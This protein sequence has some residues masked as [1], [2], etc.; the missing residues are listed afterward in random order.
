MPVNETAS[1]SLSLD[2]LRKIAEDLQEDLQRKANQGIRKK[3]WEQGIGALAS[4][5]A[6]G[7]FI[8]ICEI[9]AGMYADAERRIAERSARRKPGSNITT[10]PPS[11]PAVRKRQ[12]K[13][14]TDPADLPGWARERV[15]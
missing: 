12:T 4:I 2:D 1:P 10:L 3:D 7:E 11:S 9:R 14:G 6:L 13:Q 8:R 15:K 5:D